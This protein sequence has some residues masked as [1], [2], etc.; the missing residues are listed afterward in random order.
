[1]AQEVGLYYIQAYTIYTTARLISCDSVLVRCEVRK[2]G[3]VVT[4]MSPTWQ[5]T[6]CDWEQQPV[7]HTVHVMPCHTRYEWLV[8]FHR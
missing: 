1:M 2:R 7:H 3:A 5:H 6:G 4:M 8:L